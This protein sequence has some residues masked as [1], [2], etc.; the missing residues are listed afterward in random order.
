MTEL[1]SRI[2]ELISGNSKKSGFNKAMSTVKKTLDSSTYIVDAVND[3][4]DS[5]KENINHSVKGIPGSVGGWVAGKTTKIVGGLG[6]GVVAGTLKTIAGII[7]DSSD[8]KSRDI[9]IKISQLVDC[10]SLP[11]QKE[12]IFSLLQYLWANISSDNAIYG[13]HTLESMKKLHAKTFE[14]LK[15]LADKN[16]PILKLAKSYAPKKFFGIL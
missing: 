11:T 14:A 4:G 15:V 2:I 10:Y 12:E 3:I 6:A 13:K 1:E 5:L 16:D 7:P 8:P 9:D